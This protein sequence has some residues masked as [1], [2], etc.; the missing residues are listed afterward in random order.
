MLNKDIVYKSNP[1]YKLSNYNKLT[2][3][4]ILDCGTM[5]S[6]FIYKIPVWLICI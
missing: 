1:I 2:V 3:F 6:S 5:N 4:L